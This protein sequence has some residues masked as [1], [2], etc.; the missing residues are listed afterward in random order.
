[1]RQMDEA[2]SDFLD[3]NGSRLANDEED[4]PFLKQVDSSISSGP[5]S[6]MGAARITRAE[7]KMILR[8]RAKKLAQKRTEEDSESDSLQIIE[9]RLCHERYGAEVN[10]IREVYPLKD[11]TAIPC[12]P[13]FVLGIM[14]V[15]GQVV[16][17]LD[18]RGFF[19]LPKQPGTELSKVLIVGKDDVEC[20]I[21]TDEV[22][23]EKKIPLEMIH[24]DGHLMHGTWED[25]IM[26]VT[27]D[28]LVVIGIEKLLSDNRI[29][30]Q[31]EVG[32]R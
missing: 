18:L 25:C 26:G 28:R 22:V 23:G 27:P 8:E 19:D 2:Q 30:V 29:I 3:G 17:V 13:P 12:T 11:I 10:Y 1:M 5:A 7:K 21:L 31:Q 20:G 24:K 4:S 16:S 15:R 32:D 14:N 9:F 6:A